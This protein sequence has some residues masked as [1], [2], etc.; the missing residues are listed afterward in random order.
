[1][2]FALNEFV[3]GGH[4][5]AL[6]ASGIAFTSAI[7][8]NVKATWDILLVSYLIVYA[9]YSYNRFKE[10]KKDF[11]TNLFRSQHIEKYIKYV[12]VA[13]AIYL[14]ITVLILLFFGNFKSIFL[15]FLMI[16]LG[17][18]YTDYYK[19]FTKKI[20]GLKSFYVAFVWSLISFFVVFHYNS[21]SNYFI[22]ILI[23]SFIF[24]RWLLNTIFFDIKDIESDEKE[25]LKTIPVVFGKGKTLFY[26]HV[27][28]LISLVPII[29]GVYKHSIPLFS[30]SLVVFYFYSLYYLF[31]VKNN[32]ADIQKLSYI[33]VDGE[34]VF[35]P[36][37]LLIGNFILNV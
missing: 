22:I 14:L 3:Y 35:W 34:Y 28:N 11:L 7:L 9:I 31:A 8:L 17:F 2:K 16:L 32:S 21:T 12:P 15:V 36:I 25:K 18:L 10:F 26:L 1:M 30:L 37:A 27:L 33:M 23:F 20:I 19:K 13:I 4:L 29:I 24:L 6:G 5:L